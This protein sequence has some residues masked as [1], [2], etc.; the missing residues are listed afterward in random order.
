MLDRFLEL[1]K[2]AKQKQTPKLKSGSGVE[3]NT[4]PITF[5]AT[6]N[7]IEMAAEAALID[8]LPEKSEELYEKQFES[9][10]TG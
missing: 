9:P 8:L 4:I 10:S 3:C 5:E 6:E 1:N 2:T 7:N